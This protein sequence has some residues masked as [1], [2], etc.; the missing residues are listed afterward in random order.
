MIDATYDKYVT[1]TYN[2]SMRKRTNTTVR[3]YGIRHEY[4]GPGDFY[5]LGIGV[6]NFLEADGYDPEKDWVND[7]KISNY[8]VRDKS[9]DPK[10][11]L[12][13]MCGD[14]WISIDDLHELSEELKAA[15]AREVY[16]HPSYWT[17]NK[18][19][20]NHYTQDEWLVVIP[21]DNEQQE[22]EEQVG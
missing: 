9:Y 13:M 14:S 5:V 12:K 16:L 18:N 3:V 8:N 22:Q 21:K 7:P 20:L 15:G 19:L 17:D 11:L 1:I 2:W 4:Y 10:E 6:S